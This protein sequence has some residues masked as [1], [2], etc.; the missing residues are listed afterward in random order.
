VQCARF[1]SVKYYDVNELY[2]A[3]SHVILSYYCCQFFA[4]C[5]GIHIFM[6]HGHS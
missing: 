5:V 4:G 3:I 6:S 1:G 2:K